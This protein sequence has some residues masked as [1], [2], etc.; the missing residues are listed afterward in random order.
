MLMDDRI[1]YMYDH[2]FNKKKFR[3]LNKRIST[4][5]DRSISY[6]FKFKY[7]ETFKMTKIPLEH[8]CGCYISNSTQY[9]NY[10]IC[11]TL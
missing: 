5:K 9:C 1:L 10:G 3:L 11:V 4:I 7:I 2:S 6:K 8:T